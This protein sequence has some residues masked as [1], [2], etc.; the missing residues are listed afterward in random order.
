MQTGTKK[1]HGR[2]RPRQFDTSEAL[3]RAIGVFWQQGYAATSVDDLSAAMAL[4]RPSLYNAFG[5]KADLYRAA[6]RY[7][8]GRLDEGI[9][10]S[11]LAED[12]LRGGLQAFYEQ[13]L[14]VYFSQSPALGC[15]M[16]CTAPAEALNHADVKADLLSLINRVDNL[17]SA[18]IRQAIKTGELPANTNAKQWAKLLQA[19]LHSIALRAR[20]GESQAELQRF[21]RF[22]VDHLPWEG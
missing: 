8:C 13:A 14:Q 9:E 10:Q 17:L 4:S 1:A 12:S 6:L 2:G 19:A 15:L 18:R 7:F 20:A 11:L 3:E 21:A 22:A 16:M 5:N